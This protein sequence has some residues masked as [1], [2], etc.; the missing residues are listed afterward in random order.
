M[1]PTVSDSPA[2]PKRKKRKKRKPVEPEGTTEV[3]PV[4]ATSFE[5]KGSALSGIVLLCF[6]GFVIYSLVPQGLEGGMI[7]LLVLMGVLPVAIGSFL[8]YRAMRSGLAVDRVGAP[9]VSISPGRVRKGKRVEVE[10]ELRP[11]RA[12]LVEGVE[13][14][15]IARDDW[16]FSDWPG[17]ENESKRV[18]HEIHR[19]TRELR[20]GQ[21]RAR[22]RRQLQAS[23]V[24]P[25]IFPSLGAGARWTVRVA[26]AYAGCP[27]WAEEFFVDSHG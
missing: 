26:V 16:P 21:L 8:V 9:R 12:V 6:G 14:E 7:V 18:V 1:K 15:L 2:E 4:A 23:F 20:V 25:E 19:E 24:V 3:R 27:D 10:V 5:R 22:E 13:I 11:T 17:K